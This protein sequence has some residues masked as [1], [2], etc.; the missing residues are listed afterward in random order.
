MTMTQQTL[1]SLLQY[2]AETGVFV[3]LVNRRAGA[4]KGCEA[5]SI[6]PERFGIRYRD[7]QINGK[8]YGCHRL[9]VL[10]MTGAW[11]AGK[12]DHKDGNGLNNRWSNLRQATNSQNAGNAKLYSTNTSGFK[13]VTWNKASRRWQAG[14][15]KNGQNVYLGLFDCPKAAHEAYLAAARE[16]FGDFVRAA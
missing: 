16:H 12:V 1:K 14:I 8:L 13:G 7:I 4:R 6:K 11:P 9:A 5:G 2:D 3:W 15:K 10:Y